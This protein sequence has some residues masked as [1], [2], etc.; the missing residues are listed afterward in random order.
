[1][2]G[3]LAIICMI[4]GAGLMV[5]VPI[6]GG[7]AIGGGLY[8]AYLAENNRASEERV[9]AWFWMLGVLAIPFI[10]LMELLGFR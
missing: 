7:A 8:F 4:A 9:W 5:K 1:M 2:F 6:L 3:F 10:W